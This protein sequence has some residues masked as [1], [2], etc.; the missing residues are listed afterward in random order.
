[1]KIYTKTGDCKMSDLVGSRVRK[2]DN[3]IEMCGIND[4]AL[5]YLGLIYNDVTEGVQENLLA[6]MK[7]IFKMN[8]DL[9]NDANDKYFITGKEVHIVE[10]YID[11]LSKDLDLQKSF[12]MP[13]FSYEASIV[14]LVRTLIRK[15]ERLMVSQENIN[16]KLYP[17]INRLSDYFFVLSLNINTCEE[18]D[19]DFKE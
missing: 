15:V 8:A 6:V 5:A 2:D 16:E 1:M 13:T 14:N 10:G 12:V 3:I 18:I 19:M 7:M 11:I 4:E 9:A 17:L